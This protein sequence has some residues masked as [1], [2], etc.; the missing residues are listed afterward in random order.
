M[1]ES[2]ATRRFTGAAATPHTSAT[3]AAQRVFRDGGSAVDAAIAAAATLTVVYPQNV[4]LGGDLIALVRSPDGV[5]RCINASGWAS[6]RT[7]VQ[8]LRSRHSAGYLPFRGVETITVPGGVG[9]WESMRGLG[10]RL[11]WERLLEDAEEAAEVGVPVSA[12]LADH[13]VDPEH[14]DL[15]GMPD[16]DRVF[17]PG[18]RNLSAGELFAQPALAETFRV[19]RREG[20]QSF[21]EGTL[22]RRTV[23]FLR[24]RGSCLAEDDFA[25]F[26]PE[27]TE[28]VSVPFRGLTVSTSPPNT[29]GFVLLR[30]LRALDELGATDPLGDDLGA[31]MRIFHHANDLRSKYLA[32]PRCSVVDVEELVH[33]DLRATSTLGTVSE[34]TAPVPHGD[35]VGI[36]TADSDGY[37]VSLIQSVYGGFGSGIIDPETGVLFQNRGT[38][39]SLDESSPNVIGPRKR[40]AHTLMP[41]MTTQG[42]SVRHILSTMGGQGQPQIIAQMLLRILSGVGPEMAVAAPRSIVGIQFDGNTAESVSVEPGLPAP[43]YASLD[44]TGLDIRHVPAHT[45]AMGQSNIV[46]VGDDGSMTA[47]SDPRSDGSG[48]VVSYS[49]HASPAI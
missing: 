33:A 1:S 49:R 32:D 46:V 31:L 35:T 16:F 44:R 45:E 25:E 5:I 48:S 38:S 17:R 6:L 29:H 20:P 19:L 26:V 7:D 2:T 36:S 43:A 30:A 18:G 22:A 27:V 24:S 3:E 41:T 39:F 21:Y 13:I 23:A 4:A 42:T 15:F 28:P 9:G 14:A 11:P 34:H 12:S 10:G 8:A 40:P 47:T 37:A